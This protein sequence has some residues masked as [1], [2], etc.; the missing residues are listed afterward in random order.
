MPEEHTVLLTKLSC[1]TRYIDDLWNPL[2]PRDGQNGFSQ[3]LEG[4]YPPWLELGKPEQQERQVHFLDLY[5]WHDVTVWQSKLYDKRIKLE[6]MGL[7]L[8]VP[9]CGIEACHQMQI[10]NYYKST[11]SLRQRMRTHK[12]FPTCVGGF[13]CNLHKKGIQPKNNGSVFLQLGSTKLRRSSTQSHACKLHR[14][15]LQVKS[16]RDKT[17]AES[18]SQSAMSNKQANGK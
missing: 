15:V 17:W 16:P 8:K 2:I 14:T 1:C 6:A 4:I 12:I 7:K 11:L 5:I 9:P 3:I 18:A 10:W 13:I